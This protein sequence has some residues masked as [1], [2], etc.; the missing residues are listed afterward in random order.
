MNRRQFAK[1]CALAPFAWKLSLS[2]LLAYSGA[3]HCVNI[4]LHGFFFMEFQRD[5][6][7]A[8]SPVCEDHTF[9]FRDHG[10]AQ[11]QPLAGVIDLRPALKTGPRSKFR[12]G[13]L[14]FSKGDIGLDPNKDSIQWQ[15]SPQNFACV[16]LLPHPE[17]IVPLRKGPHRFQVQGGK[18]SDSIG[19]LSDS[20]VAVITRLKYFPSS[21]PPGFTTRN[22]YAEHC[23]KVNACDLNQAFDAARTKIFGDKFD[24][25]I[26]K[27]ENSDPLPLDGP[28]DLPD[29]MDG[30]DEQS[31]YEIRP[32]NEPKE[33][34]CHPSNLVGIESLQVAT[35]PT[36]G[37]S[38]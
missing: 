37:V 22:Y 24:L 36:F 21:T 16:L 20:N 26:D 6:L 1:A 5:T 25:K 7:V 11:F 33:T 28:A 13:T 14:Q 23:F 17:D 10:S 35:C 27:I 38:P 15:T 32:C 18:V 3:C 12:K 2:S 34:K 8:A 9:V 30:S 4:I 19:K 29:E 31:L